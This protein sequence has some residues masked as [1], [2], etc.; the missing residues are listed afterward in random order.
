MES[1]TYV[2]VQDTSLKIDIAYLSE[3]R[4]KGIC[5]K[6]SLNAYFSSTYC[7]IFRHHIKEDHLYRG[8][9]KKIL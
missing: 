2:N 9:I 1:S 5:S 7:R 8:E 3:C 6:N 4:I